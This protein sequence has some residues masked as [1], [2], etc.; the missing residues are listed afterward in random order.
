MTTRPVNALIVYA[1]PEPTSFTGAM[2]DRAAQALRGAGHR[3]EVSDLHAEGFNP[4]ARR[5]CRGC[6]P[7]VTGKRHAIV[8]A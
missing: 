1:H 3:V 6:V 7:R 8:T 5:T 2:K 4:V